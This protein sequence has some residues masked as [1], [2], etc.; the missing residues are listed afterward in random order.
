MKIILIILLGFGLISCKKTEDTALKAGERDFDFPSSKPTVQE[1]GEVD[2]SLRG[3][4]IANVNPKNSPV[5]RTLELNFKSFKK[6]QVN[7]NCTYQ[8]SGNFYIQGQSVLTSYDSDETN[9][10]ID[11]IDSISS[12]FPGTDKVCSWQK[13]GGDFLYEAKGTCLALVYPH[14]EGT[15]YFKRVK[16]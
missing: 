13:M 1:C 2:A 7:I 5:S 9:L 15:L 6:L 10:F 3:S 16:K 8:K 14:N 4:W 11:H 12:Q